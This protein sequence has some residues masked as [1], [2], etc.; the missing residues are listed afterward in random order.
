MHIWQPKKII[1]TNIKYK[2]QK[3]TPLWR[4][5]INKFILKTYIFKHH[6]LLFL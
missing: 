3:S 4:A 1:L 2:K 6:T 5:L